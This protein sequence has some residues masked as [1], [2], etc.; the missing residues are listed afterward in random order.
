MSTNASC[1]ALREDRHGG[2][3]EELCVFD[4]RV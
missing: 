2:A 1:S 3:M 4:Q